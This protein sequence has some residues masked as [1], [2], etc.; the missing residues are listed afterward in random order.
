MEMG[1]EEDE[2]VTALETGG[3]DFEKALD[4]L[5]RQREEKLVEEEKMPQN[6][7]T[8]IEIKTEVTR[9]ASEID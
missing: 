5:T 8:E 7:P 4:Q 2:V 3:G 9:L 1:F 6:G